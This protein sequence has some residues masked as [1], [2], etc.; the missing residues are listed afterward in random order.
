M[1]DTYRLPD[2]RLDRVA[3]ALLLYNFNWRLKGDVLYPYH[4]D[5]A[6]FEHAVDR[7]RYY[8]GLVDD[9]VILSSPHVDPFHM[10]Y[11]YA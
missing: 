7:L 9:D 2:G 1:S 3:Q 5:A 4:Y 10:N 8:I 6:E 11:F